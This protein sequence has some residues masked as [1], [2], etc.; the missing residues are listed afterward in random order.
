MYHMTSYSVRV[1]FIQE[2]SRRK[3]GITPPNNSKLRTLLVVYVAQ[4]MC[5]L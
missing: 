5:Q 2:T 3:C 4:V 1:I